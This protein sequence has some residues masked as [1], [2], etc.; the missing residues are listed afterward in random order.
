LTSHNPWK[1]SED[2]SPPLLLGSVTER[3]ASAAV[4]ESE[5]KIGEETPMKVS[6]PEE[7]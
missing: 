3:K 2:F 5:A 7:K 1:H 6:K 4:A